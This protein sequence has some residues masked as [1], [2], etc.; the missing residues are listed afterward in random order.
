M[1]INV[2][3]PPPGEFSK[4]DVYSKRRWWSRWRK[5]FLQS[6]QSKTNMEKEDAKLCSWWYC[7]AERWLSSESVAN[8]K[9]SWYIL[10]LMLK[11]MHVLSHFW[12]ADKKGGPSHILRHQNNQTSSAGWKCVWSPERWCH[13]KINKMSHFAESQMK[14]C[15]MNLKCYIILLLDFCGMIKLHLVRSCHSWSDMHLNH[16]SFV[17]LIIFFFEWPFFVY[18]NWYLGRK[19]STVA[20]EKCDSMEWLFNDNFCL[21]NLILYWIIFELLMFLLGKKKVNIYPCFPRLF[22][23]FSKKVLVVRNESDWILSLL[24]NWKFGISSCFCNFSSC[25]SLF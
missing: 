6:L 25:S 5:E 13:T 15:D 23:Q 18:C 14:W 21:N 11:M 12:V 16:T 19:N 20:S 9:N 17:L 4:P 10:I 7:F 8:G 22:I 2:V 3:M 24:V 1:K